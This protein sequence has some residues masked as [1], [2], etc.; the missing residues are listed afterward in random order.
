MHQN[1]EHRTPKD[2]RIAKGIIKYAECDNFIKYVA[3]SGVQWYN[4]NRL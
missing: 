4:I 2:E 1:N 3:F